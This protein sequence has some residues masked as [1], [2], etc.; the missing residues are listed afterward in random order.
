MVRE[1]RLNTLLDAGF[2]V[3][4]VRCPYP[5]DRVPQLCQIAQEALSNVVRHA[6][7]RQVV[8]ELSFLPNAVRLEI[9]D[10]GVGFDL[11]QVRSVGRGMGLRSMAER[12]TRLGGNLTVETRP[13][14]GTKVQV[15]VPCPCAAAPESTEA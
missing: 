7:A 3:H 14:A 13:G 11:D 1:M 12:A 5:P 8:V 15:E 9:R 6:Q 2:H 4:G 10:D